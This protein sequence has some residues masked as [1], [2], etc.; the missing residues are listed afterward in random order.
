M[1]RGGALA[2]QYPAGG[3]SAEHEPPTPSVKAPHAPSPTQLELYAL[4]A[5]SGR[6]IGHSTREQA[7]LSSYLP[8]AA[9]DELK[10]FTARS[11]NGAS[12]H[13]RVKTNKDEPAGN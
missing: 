12:V 2:H 3:S 13:I 5:C 6:S 9:F 10:Y 11:S 4:G 1:P 7:A 8:D